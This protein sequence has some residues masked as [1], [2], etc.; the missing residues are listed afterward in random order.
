MGIKSIV[1]ATLLALSSVANA[2][3]I[4]SA[5]CG[6]EYM[7]WYIISDEGIEVMGLP[8]VLMS[9]EAMRTFI[10]E[11]KDTSP[12]FGHMDLCPTNEGVQM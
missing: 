4:F 7:G 2:S 1:A 12:D 3:A 11:V 10:L 9:N 5:T 6:E 8:E